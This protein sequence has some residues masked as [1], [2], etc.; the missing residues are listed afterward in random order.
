[1]DTLKISL[2]ENPFDILTIS[3]TWPTSNISDDEI[4]IPGYSLTRNDRNEKYGGG[5]LAF[6]KN[7]IPYRSELS[8][9]IR[10]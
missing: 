9:R 5:T 8:H 1:M 10:I 2:N 6:F 4:S 7:T 3:E